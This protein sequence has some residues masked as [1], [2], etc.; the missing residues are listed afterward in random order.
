MIRR[1]GDKEMPEPF[2]DEVIVMCNNVL[3]VIFF[4]LCQE[5][6]DQNFCFAS[7]A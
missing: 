2:A 1:D 6:C 3:S 7:A 4:I 5:L